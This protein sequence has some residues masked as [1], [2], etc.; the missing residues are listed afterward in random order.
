MNPRALERVRQAA[1]D[2]AAAVSMEIRQVEY[3]REDIGWILR[4]TVDCAGGVSVADCERLHRPLARRLDELNLI[5]GSY[6]LEVCSPGAKDVQGV[7]DL[8]DPRASAEEEAR[9]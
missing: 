9:S 3:L 4:V 2:L 7:P 8:S 6:Y 1:M 5:P